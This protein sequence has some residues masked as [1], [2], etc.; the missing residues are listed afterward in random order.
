MKGALKKEETGVI[1]RLENFD[2][3]EEESKI[4]I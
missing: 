4:Q 2:L 3:Q 1:E